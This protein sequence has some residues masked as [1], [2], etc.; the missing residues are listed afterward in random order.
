MSVTT[1]LDDLEEELAALWGT[2]LIL[3]GPDRPGSLRQLADRMQL[4]QLSWAS[5][6]L[7]A[8][9]DA[10]SSGSGEGAPSEADTAH[11]HLQALVAW[12]R[13]FRVAWALDQAREQL[14]AQPAPRREQV[15][16]PGIT[17]TISPLGVEVAPGRLWVHGLAEDGSWVIL[18]D[19]V[20][21]DPVDPLREPATS[22]LFQQRVCYAEVLSRAIQLQDHPASGAGARVLRPV[23]YTRPTLGPATSGEARSRRA[24]TPGAPARERLEILRRPGG[25]RLGGAELTP[26]V[27]ETLA[28]NLSKRSVLCSEPL[29]GIVLRRGG[30]AILLGALD[31]LGDPCFPQLDPG[32]IRWPIARLLAAR[33]PPVVL[34]ALGLGPA[35]DEPASGPWAAQIL[36]RGCGVPSEPLP[37]PPASAPVVEQLRVAWSHLVVDQPV[38]SELVERWASEPLSRA[39][40]LEEIVLRAL[41]LGGTAGQAQL[42]AA[43]AELRRG[44]GQGGVLP[45]PVALWALGWALARSRGVGVPGV[46]LLGLPLPRL[47]NLAVSP[48][49]RWLRGGQPADEAV[50]GAWLLVVACDD[51]A[52]FLVP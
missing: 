43:T 36:A 6:R 49:V 12:V 50:L 33:I 27:S 38:P 10:L 20:Q 48:L 25:W 29:D 23:F 9:A 46:S 21:L 8:L 31:P 3:P 19:E 18:A 2:G 5:A 24:S 44:V 39:P 26:E 41:C 30:E 40:S 35:P 47:R 4:A 16:P 7:G 17:A 14:S 34:A 51:G 52:R 45:G 37:L 11:A 13:T 15:R 1:L 22:R 32:A 42:E 28:F